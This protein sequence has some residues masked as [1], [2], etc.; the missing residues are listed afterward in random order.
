MIVDYDLKRMYEEEILNRFK[1]TS[2][3]F[4]GEF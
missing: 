3:N 4:L 1:A 2:Q